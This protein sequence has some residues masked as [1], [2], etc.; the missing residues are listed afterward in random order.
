MTDCLFCKIVSGDVDADVVMR[1]PG[2]VAFKDINPAAPVHVLVVPRRHI[3]NAAFVE[4]EHAPEVAELLTS[5]RAVAEMEGIAS[6]ERGYRLV[7]NVG[8]DAL[9]SVPHLHLHVIGG[10]KMTWPPG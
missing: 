7:F 9:N 6:E 3:E 10:R 8:P 1:T 5:A 4:P 2:T